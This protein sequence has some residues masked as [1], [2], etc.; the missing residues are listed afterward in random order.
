[1]PVPG[2]LDTLPNFARSPAIAD[3]APSSVE[4]GFNTKSY[5]TLK[6]F[7]QGEQTAD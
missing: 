6:G 1:V 4:D 5:Q 2:A 7:F 3:T